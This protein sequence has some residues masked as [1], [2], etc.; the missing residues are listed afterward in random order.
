MTE[1][2]LDLAEALNQGCTCQTLQPELLRHQLAQ[3]AALKELVPTLE[4]TH[5]HL[6]SSTVVFLGQP[7]YDAIVRTVQSIERVTQLPG[8]QALALGDTA[9]TFPDR[10]LAG[11]F[12]GY[13]FHIGA[14]GPQL[15]EINTNAGGAFL[16]AALARAQA[17]CCAEMDAGWT[18]YRDMHALEDDF[19]AMFLSEWRHQRGEAPLQQVAIVDDAPDTQYLA[20]EFAL[21]RA[22]FESRG[23]PAC[24]ADARDLQWRDGR[25]WSGERAIDLVYNRLTDFDLTEPQHQ[26]LAS[27]W[28]SG[29]VVLTPDPRHY[30]LRARKTHLVQLSSAS[31]LQSLGAA[32]QDVETLQA[33][34]PHCLNV[35]AG[36]AASLWEDRRHW[37]FKPHSGFG[38]RAVYRGDK[39]TKRVW[40]SIV[41]GGYIAQS[42]VTPG[43]RSVA[44][45]AADGALKF[46][47]RAYTYA[48]QVQLLAARMYQGQ[49]TN[50]RTPGGGFAP[51]VVVT[52]A[53][54]QAVLAALSRQQPMACGTLDPR[55]TLAR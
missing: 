39:L 19:F 15:I 1:T 46:D 33:H 27:A 53:H 30:A 2:T 43:T 12:M 8:W 3:D 18:P 11:V 5:P 6:F 4:Q 21:A 37:F 44:A 29:A 48:G 35:D 49:T 36:N 55:Q 22:M 28:R 10:G 25:L 54:T 40:E 31:A 38:S 50:F 47:V 24:I 26:A 16:N 52:P 34:V 51:V 41:Q 7:A 13:D 9:T 45:A 42:L 20:P 14:N 32:S 17:A 23:I